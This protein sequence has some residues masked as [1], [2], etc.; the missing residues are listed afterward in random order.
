MCILGQNHLFIDGAVRSAVLTMDSAVLG[1]TGQK[2]LFTTHDERSVPL[3]NKH[4][5]DWFVPPAAV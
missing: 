5:L 4:R 1:L 3:P 2:D